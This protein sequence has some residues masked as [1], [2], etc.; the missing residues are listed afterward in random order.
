MNIDCIGIYGNPVIL[1][2]PALGVTGKSS[3]PVAQ[4]LKDDYYIIMPTYSTLVKGQFYESVTDE[5][6]KLNKFLREKNITQIE[7]VIASSIG[8]DI[9]MK[10]LSQTSMKINHAFIDGGQFAQISNKLR[11][12]MTPFLYFMIKS[13]YWSKGKTLKKI[14]WC[15]DKNIKP[16]FIEAGKNLDYRSMHNMMMSNLEDK[17]FPKLSEEMQRRIYFEFGSIEEHFKY[18]ENVKKAYPDANFPIFEN[19]NHMQYQIRD[20]KGFAQMLESII[21]GEGIKQCWVCCD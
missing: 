11:H 14:L 19:M 20:P 7:M 2:F 5:I 4:H 3:M 21:R 9:G 1:F 16:Y 18:R 12:I 10:F 17:P 13:L 15:D 6:R 8:A